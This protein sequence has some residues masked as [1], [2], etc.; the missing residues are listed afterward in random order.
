V[1]KYLAWGSDGVAALKLPPDHSLPKQLR[2]YAG[3]GVSAPYREAVV[4]ML[5]RL[6]INWIEGAPPSVA[7]KC[8]L[9]TEPSLWHIGPG[10]AAATAAGMTV[11]A[12]AKVTKIKIAD[13]I[14]TYTEPEVIN[15]DAAKLAAFREYLAAQAQAEGQ[16]AD[17]FFGGALSELQVMG[18]LPENATLPQRRVFYHAHR[19]CHAVTAR[20][21][22]A[23]TKELQALFP[24]A[25]AY[26]NYSPHPP[27]FGGT[28]NHTDWFVVTR[29]GGQ[30]LGW[31]EDWATGGSWGM[32]TF[33]S[34]SYYAALVDCATR[35]T[36]DRKST[37][38][39]SSYNS[40]SRMPSSA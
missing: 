6:G 28:M 2:F 37:R 36:G 16:K 32:G 11:E 12:R 14:G 39:N 29:H 24:N 33:Q 7:Q 1:R 15:A 8:G 5:A 35:K 23:H 3:C 38:L 21:Y 10:K 4:E 19:F 27:M 31:G 34:V 13:E 20:E 25:R 26:N 30:S 18:K 9:I 22:A 17:E 40:E